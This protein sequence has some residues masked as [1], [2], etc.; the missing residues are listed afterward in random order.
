WARVIMK[1]VVIPSGFRERPSSE[2]VGAAIEK[3]IRHVNP[4]HKA[5][6]LARA[7][8]GGGFVE[9]LVKQQEGGVLP[10]EVVGPV[11][12]R[13]DSFCGLVTENGVKTAVIEMAA[14][15]GLRHV[16]GDKRNPLKTTT[17]GVGETIIKAL[18]HGAER[19]LIGCGDSGTSD[20]GVGMAQ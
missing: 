3:G 11:G 12:K 13:I 8:G 2:E 9:T 16:P 17:Y 1:V 18:D 4:Q 14:I 20:G 10:T 7:D 5:T 19:I 15:A 6:V